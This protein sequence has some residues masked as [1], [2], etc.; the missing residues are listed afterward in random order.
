M[1]EIKFRAWDKA[2]NCFAK[3]WKLYLNGGVS[4][5]DTWA[6]QDV[7]LNQYT[8]LKDASGRE[9]YEGD[10]VKDYD[11]DGIH[12]I[13]YVVDSRTYEHRPMQCCYFAAVRYSWK[14]G[15]DMKPRPI[16]PNELD[17]IEII[18][19]IYENKELLDET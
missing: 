11:G 18:G 1:R 3:N 5:E 17:N 10:I 16:H 9:I 2:C 8:G 14:E 13:E 7:E 19:N 4:I 12:V 15:R 6:T